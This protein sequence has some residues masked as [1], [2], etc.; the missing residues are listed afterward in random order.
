MYTSC[1]HQVDSYSDACGLKK[2]L[3]NFPA[4][5]YS[6]ANPEEKSCLRNCMGLEYCGA[7]FTVPFVSTKAWEFVSLVLSSA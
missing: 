1:M 7:R 6:V 3:S 5:R 4:V 2:N